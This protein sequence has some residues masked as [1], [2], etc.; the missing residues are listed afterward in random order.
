VVVE[1]LEGD[2]DC[3]IITGRVYNAEAMPPY[4]LPG[5][6]T[7]SGIKSRTTKGGTQSNFNELRFEDKLGSEEVYLHAEKNWT[8]HV[9]DGESETV[10]SS[11]SSSA[12]GSIS[13]NAGADHSRTANQNINDTAG[14]N[15][16]TNS[17]KNMTLSA[18]GAY[19]LHTN[20]G[21]HL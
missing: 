2:P 7:Q 11:I 19:E 18:G 15:I 12:G 10:G 13:R 20:L 16:A 4:G 8:I 1:F 17:G 9:K 6:A 21:I 3:P 14:V 5:S